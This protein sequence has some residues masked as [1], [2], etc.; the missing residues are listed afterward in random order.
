MTRVL[1]ALAIGV[2]AAC[3]LANP[4]ESRQANGAAP[5]SRVFADRAA[6]YVALPS[7]ARHD[8]RH[9]DIFTPSVTK[10]FHKIIRDAFGGRDG[11]H[12][13]RTIQEG[14]PVRAT[15]LHVNEVYPEEIPLTTMPPMLLRRLPDLPMELAYRIVGRALVLQE[16]KTNVIVDFIPDAIPRAH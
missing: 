9:G 3:A 8:S 11:R 14:D 12:M 6:A 16:I 1:W 13:R 15:T 2:G 10:Q 5:A 4:A 7:A